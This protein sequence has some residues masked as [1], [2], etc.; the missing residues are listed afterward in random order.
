MRVDSVAKT[1]LAK[2]VLSG[3]RRAL[4][5]AISVVENREK[6][7]A[8][9]MRSLSGKTGHAFVLGITG[10]P[11]TG[12]ST[13]VDKLIDKYRAKGLSVGVV[14]VD[15]TSP[16][17]G[18]ALLGDR[19]RMLRHTTDKGVFIR[20]M[21]SRGSYG[22]L[23]KSTAEVIQIL[24][25]AGTE[26]IFIETVGIGQSDIEIV[27]LAHAVLVVLM[28]GL[29]DDVQV[30]KAGLMEVG[31]IYVV[32]K[33]DLEGA[34]LMALNLFSMARETKSRSVAVLKVS[35]L[36]DDGVD[37]LVS[38]IEG[39]R[40]KLH[41]PQGKEMRQRS[42][43]GM[44]VEMARSELMAGFNQANRGPVPDRLADDVIS[45]K[46]DIAEAARRLSQK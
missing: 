42:I 46:L 33:S 23:A 16:L 4:A 28:P 32:N 38:T 35:A 17:T 7:Y 31:D 1:A 40:S 36:K 22:G 10:P 26:V 13:L 3:D 27:R 8:S 2:Q 12:K 34:D 29:G 43:K 14:A 25:A 45:G 11:G 6:N 20:S 5:K 41:T 19:V 44:I 37:K 9:L 21:A 15:P 18:G 39:I 24:D 30:S